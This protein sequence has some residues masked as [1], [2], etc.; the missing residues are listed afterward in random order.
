MLGNTLDGLRDSV[1]QLVGLED[2]SGLTDAGVADMFCEARR[3]IDRL[4]SLAARALAC[5]E[6]RGIPYSQ[7]A[8]SVAA[9]AQWHTGQRWAEAKA[10]FDAGIA[11]EQLTL[12]AKAW[13]DGDISASVARSIC[14]GM[15]KGHEDVYGEIE[16]ILVFFAAE[17]N[18]C[19]LD[20]L[21]RHYVKCCDELDDREPSDKN[22]AHLSPVGNRWILEADLDAKG[23]AIVQ[24][25]LSAALDT[26]SEGDDRS[27]AK[28]RGDAVVRVFQSF[29]DHEVLGLE[30]GERPH[31]TLTITWDEIMSW[32]PIRAL[33][34]DPSDLAAFLTRADKAQIL[35][36]C[37]I[38]RIVLGPD[39]QPLDV[40]REHRTAPLYLRRAIAQ[41]DRHCRFPGC[42]RKSSWCEAHHVIPWWQD[43]PTNINNLVLLCPFHHHVVHRQGWTNTFDGT[44]YTVRNQHGTRLTQCPQHNTGPPP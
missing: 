2:L 16:E 31:V 8:T 26:P 38:A 29:L 28:L 4:E 33:P 18:L 39:S 19:D 12:T 36:D 30:G 20:G 40:G 10:S 9:W 35:C 32:L 24:K 14:R 6:G 3:E 22:G 17:R 44:T 25:G 34:N 27:P 21:I 23:G 11:C 42:D 15:Q 41:R 13:A 37:N 5:V 1:D 7:G 43:G